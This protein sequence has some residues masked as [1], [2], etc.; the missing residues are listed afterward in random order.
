MIKRLLVLLVAALL[1][2]PSSLAFGDVLIEPEDN[3]FQKHRDECQRVDRS[4]LINCNEGFLNMVV[5]PQ[6]TSTLGQAENGAT[7]YVEYTYAGSG[8]TWGL[9]IA[10][11]QN[12]SDKSG[13]FLMDGLELIYDGISFIEDHEYEF[14][15]YEGDVADLKQYDKLVLWT[16]P[17]SGQTTGY[18]YTS[19]F[20]DDYMDFYFTRA[21]LDDQGLEWG[22]VG[23]YYGRQDS[24]VC[25]SD[26]TATDLGGGQ[27]TTTTTDIKQ[28][29]DH[30]DTEISITLNTLN[31]DTTAVKVI[32]I[33]VIIIAGAAAYLIWRH[34][35]TKKK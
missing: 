1:L 9:G 11:L 23:Y 14:Y 26:P 24:W 31:T 8:G 34:Y 22:Y 33:V 27:T 25:I 13:W 5:S 2:V 30:K 35:A 32:V 18:L 7:V 20:E 3:F 19:F 17:N 28:P 6:N 12:G 10:Y 21:Y 4:Y 16:Y 15:N 29:R